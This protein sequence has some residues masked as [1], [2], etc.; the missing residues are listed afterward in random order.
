VKST[1]ISTPQRA[2]QP[3]L[4]LASGLSAHSSESTAVSPE[5]VPVNVSVLE[6]L[7]GS[8]QRLVEELLREFSDSA[9]V[10]GQELI[11]CCTALRVTQAAEIAHKLKSSARSVGALKLGDLCEL[12]E[13][14]SKSVDVAACSRLTPQFE[15]ELAS[16]ITFLSALKRQ[17]VVD[18]QS[19]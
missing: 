15:A 1:E 16:V 9:G 2:E 3:A 19:A 14:A 5:R 13:S 17:S 8:D 11:D 6:S 18:R 4:G 7:V 12:I 10:M